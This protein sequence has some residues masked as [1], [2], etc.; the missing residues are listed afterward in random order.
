[1]LNLTQLKQLKQHLGAAL[2]LGACAAPAAFADPLLSI[3]ATPKPLP[4]GTTVDLDVRIAGISDLYAY[5]F[6]L[7]FDPAVLQL[8][9]YVEGDFLSSAGSTSAGV[10]AIDNALGNIS[11]K[12]GSLLGAVP[13]AS[14]S[15]SLVH[16]GFK[17]IGTGVT[18]LYFNDVLFLDAGLNDIGV[19]F[20]PQTLA[21][22]SVP[23]PEAYLMLGLGLVGIAALRRRKVAL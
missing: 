18:N 21:V 1:M 10:A 5:Q 17:V 6:S 20:G 8:H 22:A 9:F 14:G 4:F 13:G 12:Y 11:Y 7:A 23:E 16:F 19:Q 3:A 2:L 15:G